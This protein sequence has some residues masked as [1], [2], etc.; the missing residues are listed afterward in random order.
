MTLDPSRQFF[1]RF[2]R[3]APYCTPLTTSLSAAP[4]ADTSGAKRRCGAKTTNSSSSANSPTS[5]SRDRDRAF[6][7][8]EAFAAFGYICYSRSVVQRLQSKSIK[9]T[10][11]QLIQQEARSTARISFCSGDSVTECSLCRSD[12]SEWKVVI[13]F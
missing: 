7:D 1:S 3:P 8:E 10:L 6:L 2:H 13:Q 4:T 5:L 9:H 11:T 12:L